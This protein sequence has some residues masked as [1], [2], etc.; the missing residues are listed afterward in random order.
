MTHTTWMSSYWQGGAKAKTAMTQPANAGTDVASTANPGFVVSVAPSTAA[1]G[2][3]ATTFVVT[4][5]PT[6][7]SAATVAQSGAPP[8][9]LVLAPVAAR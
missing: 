4:V 1:D 7:G 8:D 2:K 9:K 6:A 3:G 5:S